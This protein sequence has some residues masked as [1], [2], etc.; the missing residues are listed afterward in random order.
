MRVLLDRYVAEEERR[1]IAESYKESLSELREDRLEF[2][3]DV[4]QLRKMMES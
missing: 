3:N 1:I 2:S 4:G